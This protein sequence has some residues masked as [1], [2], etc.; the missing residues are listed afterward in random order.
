MIHVFLIHLLSISQN[1]EIWTSAPITNYH[2]SPIEPTPTM[3]AEL[4]EY[5]PIFSHND[6][7]ELIKMPHNDEPLVENIF[8]VENKI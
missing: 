7:D 5:D 3:N 6:N 1:Y 8:E 4:G 2:D